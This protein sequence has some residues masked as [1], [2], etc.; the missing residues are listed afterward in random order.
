MSDDK[1]VSNEEIEAHISTIDTH[2]NDI[3]AHVTEDERTAK[4]LK[5][6]VYPSLVAFVLLAAYGYFLVHSLTKDVHA[7]MIDMTRL[8][9]NVS[10]NMDTVAGSMVQLTEHTRVM[11]HSTANM[12]HDVR[13]LNQNISPPM[14]FMNSFMPW[15]NDTGQYPGNYQPNWQPYAPQYPP[16]YAPQYAPPRHIQMQPNQQQ[17]QNNE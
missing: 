12:Q 15:Q 7:L 16:Q 17:E 10:T 3:E 9:R 4:H 2:V 6:L 13:G 1:K 11:A 14:N 8:T 5:M